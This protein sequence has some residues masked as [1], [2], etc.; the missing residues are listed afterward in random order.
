[1]KRLFSIAFIAS[2]LAGTGAA[3]AELPTYEC[4]GFPITP[5]Q[6]QV[7][8]S[9]HVEEQSPTPTLMLSDMPA[10]PHQVAVLRPRARMDDETIAANV[11]STG[12]SVR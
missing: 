11:F 10:S 7:L 9:A 2:A 3:A 8:G 4:M 1:M 12:P 6:F 5:H